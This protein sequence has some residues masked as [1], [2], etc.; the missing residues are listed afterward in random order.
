MGNIYIGDSKQ[1]IPVLFDTGS[2][3]VYVLTDKCDSALCPQNKKFQAFASGTYKENS[4]GIKDDLAHCYGQGCVNGYVSRD[5][6][7]F[8]KDGNANS[9]VNGA[10][11]LA[12]KEAT[13][14]DKDKFSGIV[15]LGPMSDIARMPAFLEQASAMGSVGNSNDVSPIFSFYLS[16]SET[17]TGKLTFGGYNLASYA[18]PG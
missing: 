9:C 8:T 18:K 12:V 1:E 3:M 16:N 4:D 17:K 15:G 6:I 14:I 13:D 11:F 5:N 2:P 7:C 10:T